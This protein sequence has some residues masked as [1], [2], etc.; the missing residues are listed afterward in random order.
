[1]SRK[2]SNVILGASTACAVAALGLAAA[3]AQAQPY[4]DQYDQPAYSDNGAT[5]G[6]LVVTAPRHYERTYSGLPIERLTAARVVNIS[7]LDLSTGWGV[8]EL[9]ARV[10]RAAAD[11]CDQL[12][13]AW[14]MGF[15]PVNGNDADCQARAVDHAMRAAPIGY[16]GYGY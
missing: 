2:L 16:T 4:Y 1:M 15:Y 9:H 5:V 14:T 10:V 13:S 11:A 7:D 12:D 3:P 6:G 8:H